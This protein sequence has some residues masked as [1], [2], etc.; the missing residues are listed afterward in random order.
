MTQKLFTV[1]CR[2]SNGTGTMW[3]QAVRAQDTDAAKSKGLA[4]CASD[5]GYEEADIAVVGVAKGRAIILDWDDE[6]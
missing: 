6:I 5:W 4:L 1:F 2:E 3:I